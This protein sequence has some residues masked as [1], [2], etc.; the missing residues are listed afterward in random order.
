MECIPPTW[1]CDGIDDCEDGSDEAG[2]LCAEGGYGREGSMKQNND[3]IG[4]Q[5]NDTAALAS[6]TDVEKDSDN[7]P[8]AS[9]L[10]KVLLQEIFSRRVPLIHFE[11]H[12]ALYGRDLSLV[13]AGE[14]P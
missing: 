1:T 13:E 2:L 6:V 10:M 3:Q 11:G 8:F 5:G 7:V 14:A 9:F 12:G 4:M